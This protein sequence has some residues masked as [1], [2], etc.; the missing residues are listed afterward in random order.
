MELCMFE[1]GVRKQKLYTVGAVYMSRVLT[2]QE[3][4]CSLEA[5]KSS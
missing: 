5:V 3:H 2:G 4:R 1:Y